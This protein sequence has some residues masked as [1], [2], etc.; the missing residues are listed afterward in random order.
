MAV[1]S[2]NWES[3]KVDNGNYESLQ[4]FFLKLGSND[5]NLLLTVLYFLFRKLV[6]RG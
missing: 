4:Y 2:K 3:W 6:G 5:F 1:A